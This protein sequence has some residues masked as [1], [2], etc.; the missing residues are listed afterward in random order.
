MKTEIKTNELTVAPKTT[1]MA[2]KI[3]CEMNG[4]KRE[5]EKIWIEDLPEKLD[6]ELHRIESNRNRPME[7]K[8]MIAITA[9][10][11]VALVG[12]CFVAIPLAAS[13]LGLGMVI[14]GT[15]SATVSMIA[16]LTIQPPLGRIAELRCCREGLQEKEF[17]TFV[18]TKKS[19]SEGMP[20][21]EW[22]HIHRLYEE[23]KESE[24]KFN[25]LVDQLHW[26]YC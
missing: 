24:R 9:A 22:L 25:E 26:K 18:D 3:P 23:K 11:I 2:P 12:V 20:L 7:Q 13:A 10:I 6:I 19:L 16:L 1:E 5:I 14:S 21:K 4:K 17:L 15:I 8:L